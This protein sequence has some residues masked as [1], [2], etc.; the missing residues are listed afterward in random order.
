M[1]VRTLDRWAGSRWEVS[2]SSAAGV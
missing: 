1:A 2:E